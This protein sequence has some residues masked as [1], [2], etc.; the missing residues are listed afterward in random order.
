MTDREKAKLISEAITIAK[1][2]GTRSEEIRAFVRL[3]QEQDKEI[4]ELVATVIMLI[5]NPDI[6]EE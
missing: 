5:E 4:A 3:Y 2:Y 6:M 1:K